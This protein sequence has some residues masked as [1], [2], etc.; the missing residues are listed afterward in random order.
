MLYLCSDYTENT[1]LYEKTVPLYLIIVFA[2]HSRPLIA[3]APASAFSNIVNTMAS[4]LMSPAPAK[5]PLPP[6]HLAV[7]LDG[8]PSSANVFAVATLFARR[9]SKVSIVHIA[10]PGRE[11][12]PFSMTSAGITATF[13]AQCVTRFRKDQWAID[14]SARPAGETTKSALLARIN[15]LGANML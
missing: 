1:T 5:L 13:E 6:R 14:I 4:G 11:D 3:D 10:I 7:A 2:A 12:I 15:K 9:D 8:S